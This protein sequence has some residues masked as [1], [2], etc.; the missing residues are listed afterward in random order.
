MKTKKWKLIWEVAD[1]PIFEMGHGTI[2]ADQK[3]KSLFGYTTKGQLLFAKNE[4]LSSYHTEEDLKEASLHGFKFYSDEK[5]WKF[6]LN[7]IK[8]IQDK[9]KELEKKLEAVFTTQTVDKNELGRL[10]LE[11]SDAQVLTFCHFNMTNP[12][13]TFGPEDKLRQ[14]LIG[15]AGGQADEVMGVLTTPEKLSTLQVETLEFYRILKKYWLRI[16]ESPSGLAK[17][18]KSHSQKYLYLGGN[19]GNDKWDLEYYQNLVNEL[20]NKPSFNLKGEIQKIE[21]YSQNINSQKQSIFRK[22][23]IDSVYKSI[24]NKLAETGHARLELRVMWSSQYRMLRKI[25]YQISKIMEIPAYDLLVCTPSELYSWFVLGK[26]QTNKEVIDRRKAYLF[27]LNG[28]KVKSAYGDSA[29]SLK[30]KLIP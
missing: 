6:F 27:V 8:E 1:A 11:V 29:I 9:N 17:D 20:L 30:Q 21:T 18:L 3:Q 5:K 2:F 12:N 16:K 24:A 28:K 4:I 7:G 23:K 26:K 25:V 10:L 13:F 15:V 19:E 14:Y 22:H